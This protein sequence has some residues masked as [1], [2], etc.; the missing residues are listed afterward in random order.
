MR[1]AGTGAPALRRTVR[2]FVIYAAVRLCAGAAAVAQDTDAVQRIARDVIP[3]VER[4]VGL[5]FRRPPIVASR[6][7][8][9]V[10]AY[11][12]RKIAQEMPPA[13]IRGV[14]RA[15]R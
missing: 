3:A 5:T 7:R 12:S 2:A 15:Y 13:E 14:E 4:A 1:A 6:S 11:L 9:Q 10:R 8:D